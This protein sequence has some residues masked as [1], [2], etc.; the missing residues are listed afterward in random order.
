M[1][2][3]ENP[4]ARGMDFRLVYCGSGPPL[5]GAERGRDGLGP[6]SACFCLHDLRKALGLQEPR[7]PGAF[8]GGVG[9]HVQDGWEGNR[10]DR[11]ENT[12]NH[13]RWDHSV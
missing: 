7:F 9:T 11:R 10:G 6:T 12:V 3:I 1:T 4:T 2:K 13:V 5:K 8:N